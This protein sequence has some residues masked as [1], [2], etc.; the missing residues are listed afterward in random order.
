MKKRILIIGESCRDKFVYCTAARLAPDIPV[1]V[2]EIL[3]EIEN[4]GMAKNLERNVKA[5]Y[6]HCDIVTNQNWRDIVKVRYMHEKSNH[7]FMRVDTNHRMERANVR[8]LP[9]EKYDIVAISDYDKGFLSQKDIQY[10]CEHHDAVFVDTKKPVGSWLKSA[11]YIK[12]N[13]HEYERSRP[14][15]KYFEHKIICTN[16]DKG[17]SFRGKRYPV[18]KVEVRDISGAGD[19]FFAGL[20][21][22]YI[23]NGDMEDSIR[24]ANACAAEVVKHRGVSVIPKSLCASS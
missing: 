22:R 23:Q 15:P 20:L 8:R 16:G 6:K 2:L 3:Q 4:P 11:A 1:P 13:N 24:F 7:A 10:I 17:A 14:L 18:E 19:S 12:I 9:L 5:L 21:V